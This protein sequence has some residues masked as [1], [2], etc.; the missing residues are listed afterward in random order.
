M[1]KLVRG[2]IGRDIRSIVRLLDFARGVF[3]F[4]GDEEGGEI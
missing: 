4:W 2:R 3:W 1:I